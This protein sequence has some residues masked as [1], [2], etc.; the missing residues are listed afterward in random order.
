MK[1]R[2][3]TAADMPQVIALAARIHIDH[4][5][6]DDVIIERRTFFP[7]GCLV[8]E[9]G[10]A[11]YGYTLVHPAEFEMPPAL[12]KL[13]GRAPRAT[14]TLHIHDVALAPE[15]RGTGAAQKAL[16]IIED[17]AKSNAYRQISIVAVN[18]TEPFWQ[19]Q[20]FKHHRSEKLDKKLASY[21]GTSSY[22]LRI[23]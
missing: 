3:M 8:L 13:I 10:D 6:D 11:I 15:A 19:K 20:G 4:P 12:N 9:S 16:K 7:E 14:D 18:G 21:D 17:T 22:M 5:E 1:W 2:Q 23:L